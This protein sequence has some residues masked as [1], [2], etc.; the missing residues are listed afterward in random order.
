MTMKNQIKPSTLSGPLS[1]FSKLRRSAKR[2]R[3]TRCCAR[4]GPDCDDSMASLCPSPGRGAR[5]YRL[6]SVIGTHRERPLLDVL[7][8]PGA[9]MRSTR[10]R[11]HFDVERQ[12]DF[13]ADVEF[14]FG[15]V[16]RQFERVAVGDWNRLRRIGFAG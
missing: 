11:R 16:E 10:I 7:R 14:G 8:G 3:V 5:V 4:P 2:S 6:E 9:E 12:S 13:D 1:D 15:F